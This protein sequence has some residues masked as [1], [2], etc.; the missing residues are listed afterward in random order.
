MLTRQCYTRNIKA[1]GPAVLEEMSFEAIV[2][3]GR[4]TTE[5]GHW[6]MAI[7][8]PERIAQ[9]SQKSVP[10][11]IN[12]R[13]GEKS[14]VRRRFFFNISLGTW[15]TLMHEKPCLIPLFT[16]WKRTV[17]YMCPVVPL[18]IMDASLSQ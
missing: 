4:R 8:H 5:D 1:L 11:T 6:L 13:A 16:G 9:V 2:N 10:Y 14:L 15:Q 7:A 17:Q 3:D 18:C 12:S